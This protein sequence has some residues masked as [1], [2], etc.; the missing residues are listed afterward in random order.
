M[1]PD[2]E[3]FILDVLR[4]HNILTLATVREDGYPQA[5]TVGYV[6]EGLTLY[7]GTFAHAQKVANIRRCPKVSLTIDRDYDDWSQ[8]KGL[9]MG[10][11]AEILTDPEEIPRV[12]VLFTTKFP[13]IA[14]LPV[15]IDPASV[16]FLKITPIVI[17][18]LDYTKG[19]GHTELISIHA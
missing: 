10:G 7:I 3:R 16:V 13:Q 6:H 14:A 4:A 12:A 18:V 8:I 9:S 17:S 19:F 11:T 2:T 5:T 15:P 1:Q